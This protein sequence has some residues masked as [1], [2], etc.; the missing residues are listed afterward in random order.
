M[1]T[2]RNGGKQWGS[3]VVGRAAQDYFTLERTLGTGKSHSSRAESQACTH[4]FLLGFIFP[5]IQWKLRNRAQHAPSVSYRAESHLINNP[6][7]E[8]EFK[9][10]IKLC[11]WPTGRNKVLGKCVLGGICCPC[12]RF[13]FFPLHQIKILWAHLCLMSLPVPS[14]LGLSRHYKRP[15]CYP[16]EFKRLE[17]PGG[18]TVE[19][20]WL[21]WSAFEWWRTSFPLV[22]EPGNLSIFSPGRWG[23][24]IRLL[25][26]CYMN[27]GLK[28]IKEV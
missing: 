12:E 28:K 23:V 11:L 4:T 6:D 3:F 24:E 22:S 25:K 20:L 8:A 27:E 13:D 2:V 16:M 26:P 7:K 17:R 14:A 1:E 21:E 5:H 19:K 10:V 9:M 15:L 18:G